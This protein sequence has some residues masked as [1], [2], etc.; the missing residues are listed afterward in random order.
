MI[1]LRKHNLEQECPTKGV[2]TIRGRRWLA[3]LSLGSIDRPEM[4]QLLAQ[5]KLW[6]EQ[7]EQAEAE[8]Q[9]RQAKNATACLLATQ[10]ARGCTTPLHRTEP[11]YDVERPQKTR[12]RRYGEDSGCIGPSSQEEEALADAWSV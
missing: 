6:D 5:W 10:A 3:Q 2:D 8:I 4:D 9:K 1:L 12:R 11:S 7:I